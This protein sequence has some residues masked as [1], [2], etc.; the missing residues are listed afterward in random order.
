LILSRTEL[1]E[2]IEQR[3][4][5]DAA[6]LRQAWTASS[7]VPHFVVDDLIPE[8]SVRALSQAFPDPDRLM[9]RSTWRER[10]RVGVDID[11][12]EPIV[13]DFLYAFQTPEICAAVEDITDI[14]GIEVDP[15]LYAS[16]ISTMLEGDFLNP[17]LDNSHDG[18]NRRYRVINVLFY[19]SPGWSSDDGGQLEVWNEDV[20]EAHEVPVRFN[21]LVVMATNQTS[22]HSVN[23]VRS[24]RPRMCV[25]NYY[26]SEI[27]PGG[28]DYAHVTTFAG[29][30]EHPFLRAFMRV[31][32]FALNML[33]RMFPFLTTNNPHQRRNQE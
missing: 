4:R 2:I 23:P 18:E 15:S 11:A 30:P 21:R 33:G 27:P 29:R 32:A 10:K 5:R 26:F 31:D 14:Q 6:S 13:G 9:R 1:A 17:H 22:W 16:G 8:E 25:S 3:L 19:P 24:S 20:T 12:Y 28:H 7:P